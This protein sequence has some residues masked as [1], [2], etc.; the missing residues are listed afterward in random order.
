MP[1]DIS[2]VRGIGAE[3][4]RLR[5]AFIATA[6]FAALLWVIKL[7]ELAFAMD[8]SGFGI[9]PRRPEAL[10]GVLLAPLLH[11]SVAHLFANTLPLLIL[12]T[13][14][15]YGYP[16]AARIALPLIYIGSG[17]GV[18]LFARPAF[19]IGAS[20]LTF[21]MMFFVFAMGLLRWDRRAIALSMVVFFLY[22]GMIWGIFPSAPGISF[23]Y[24]FFGAALGVLL[25]VI[26]RRIDPPPPEKKY[27]WE[28][29][30]DTDDWPGPSDSDRWGT[31]Q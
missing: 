8:L 5:Q 27:D 17:A 26:L 24:H 14:S 12:G 10:T 29:E 2:P 23:E 1:D 21:G 11:G 22:G 20:G 16:R 31:G 6:F 15:L 4:L 13:A 7:S 9:Y 19:H 3:R 25:A 30:D 18:W 28:G